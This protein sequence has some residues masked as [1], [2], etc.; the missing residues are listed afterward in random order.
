M[1]LAVKEMK[2]IVPPAL[3][4]ELAK[5]LG[6]ESL[7]DLSQKFVINWSLMPQSTGNAS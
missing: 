5:D 6:T 3:D 7:E 1:S 2:E 4:D